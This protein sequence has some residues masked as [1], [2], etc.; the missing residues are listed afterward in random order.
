MSTQ[1]IVIRRKDL[2]EGRNRLVTREKNHFNFFFVFVCFSDQPYQ[3]THGNKY[4]C[5]SRPILRNLSAHVLH[6]SCTQRFHQW[7]MF[8]S[9]I[10]PN[11]ILQKCII[12]HIRFLCVLSQRALQ[13]LRLIFKIALE[14]SSLQKYF[15]A[16]ELPSRCI[17]RKSVIPAKTDLS[18]NF[19]Y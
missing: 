1:A 10:F 13:I 14:Y 2:S 18:E 4:T 6:V 9:W 8:I 15:G 7:F 16:A 3:S 12:P 11:N 19:K 5:H 17:S